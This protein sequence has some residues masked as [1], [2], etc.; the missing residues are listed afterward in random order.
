MTIQFYTEGKYDR[1]AHIV[2]LSFKIPSSS[3]ESVNGFGIN[4]AIADGQTLFRMIE[5]IP[6]KY[7]ARVVCQYRMRINMTRHLLFA[8]WRV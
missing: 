1:F 7:S 5:R 3:C 8:G 6:C 4:H 2:R